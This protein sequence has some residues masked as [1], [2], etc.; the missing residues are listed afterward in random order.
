M[1]NKF[2]SVNEFIDLLFE[3]ASKLGTHI[4]TIDLLLETQFFID[5]GNLC[6]LASIFYK[7]ILRRGWDVELYC[8]IFSS[9]IINSTFYKNPRLQFH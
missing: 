1:K 6:R 5:K 9:N 3:L 8:L 4:I 7:L 2:S